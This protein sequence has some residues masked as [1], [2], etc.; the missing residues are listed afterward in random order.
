MRLQASNPLLAFA[1]SNAALSFSLALAMLKFKYDH[2]SLEILMGSRPRIH[3]LFRQGH[4]VHFCDRRALKSLGPLEHLVQLGH[5]AHKVLGRDLGPFELLILG[6]RELHRLRHRRLLVE[7]RL[8]RVGWMANPRL[9]REGLPLLLLLLLL[10]L[11]VR[12]GDPRFAAAELR[13]WHSSNKVRYTMQVAACAVMGDPRVDR[14]PLACPPWVTP[15][16][17]D[18]DD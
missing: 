14:A 8:A 17:A 13:M 3:G 18:G 12:M 7:Q 15:R 1:L 16:D 5:S 10:L 6:H 9:L 4:D 2:R 11:L